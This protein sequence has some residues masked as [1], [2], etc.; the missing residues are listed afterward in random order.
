MGSEIKAPFCK[1]G[2]GAIHG[3][4]R[5]QCA[6]SFSDIG[7]LCLRLFH[8]LLFKIKLS[9]FNNYPEWTWRRGQGNTVEVFK[10]GKPLGK[11]HKL[12][13]PGPKLQHDTRI[14]E[15]AHAQLVQCLILSRVFSLWSCDEQVR[16]TIPAVENW[17]AP[18]GVRPG[19]QSVM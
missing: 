7:I 14:V 16:R 3:F 6:N 12:K 1:G 18:E 17:L 4:G 13:T 19:H 11:T 5:T 10:N 2:G 8:F 9:T 15:A